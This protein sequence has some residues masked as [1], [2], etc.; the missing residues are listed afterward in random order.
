M[1]ISLETRTLIF[2]KIKTCLGDFVP[3]LVVVTN[4]LDG[5]YEVIGNH[6]VPYG[7][8]KKMVPGMFFASIVHRKES[9][10]FHFFPI[11]MNPGLLEFAPALNK[12]LKGKTCYHFKEES[13][14]VETEL[15]LLLEE[16][17][18]LWGKLQYI[19]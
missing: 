1:A 16:G 5:S 10:A 7:Y 19:V 18:K 8:D 4:S 13:Q 11:Y 3:P 15:K 12:F 9:V 14:V 2:N 17:I 6:P